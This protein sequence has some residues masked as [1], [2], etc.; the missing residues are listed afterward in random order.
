MRCEVWAGWGLAGALLVVAAAWAAPVVPTLPDG[1]DPAQAAQLQPRLAALQ[2]L[3]PARRE[4]LQ[5]RMAEWD[6]LPVAERRA[7]RDAWQAWQALPEGERARLRQAAA[8]YAALAP[9]QQQ[10]L[11]AQ[12][13]QLDAYQRAGWLLGPELGA[14]WPRLHG[15]LALVPASQRAE[16]LDA[17][18]ALD[19][20][21]RADLA[22]L[23]QRTAPESRDQLRR[24]LL[25]TPP[26]NRAGWLRR[27]VAP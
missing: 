18:R 4:G 27:E 19:A 21:A 14:D 15:L 5:A 8:D 16:L 7:R 22:V 26:E 24:T 6:A 20:G 17:L 1:V 23:A 12:F 3:P 25:S 9:A 11:S 13:A 10:A 2:A